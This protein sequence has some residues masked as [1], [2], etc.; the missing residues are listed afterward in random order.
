MGAL[1]MKTENRRALWRI[2]TYLRPFKKELLLAGLLLAAATVIG[3]LQPLVIQQITDGGMLAQNLP[4][5]CQAVVALA[6]LVALNQAVEMA[7]TRLFVNIHNQSY[8]T[9]FHQVF[10][11]LLRLKKHILKIKTTRK[12]SASYRWTCPRWPPSPTAIR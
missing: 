2:L 9:V 7:Q 1:L 11:K 3:F 6:L 4:V 10:Q 8:Y 12:F 5:L